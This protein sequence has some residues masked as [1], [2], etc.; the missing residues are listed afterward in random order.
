ML[1]GFLVRAAAV[2][3][4]KK[5]FVDAG[6]ALLG[7]PELKALSKAFPGTTGEWMKAGG[8][9]FNE[10]VMSAGIFSACAFAITERQRAQNMA[11]APQSN[12]SAPGD[13]SNSIENLEYI[14]LFKGTCKYKFVNRESFFPCDSSVTFTN[15]KN[16]TSEF[17]FTA[18]DS[19]VIFIFSGHKD[20]Q[21]NLENYF[22]SVDTAKFGEASGKGAQGKVEGECHMR[23]NEDGSTFYEIKCDV[24]DRKTGISFNF[25]LTDISSIEKK[26]FNPD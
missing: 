4:D 17:K 10:R 23:M 9:T 2:C 21:P 7:T 3:D 16:H 8:E 1:V 14:V 18:Q 5:S 6:F 11:S 13:D 25:Y 22:L 26:Y 19:A 12:Q 24:F 20:R 15:F